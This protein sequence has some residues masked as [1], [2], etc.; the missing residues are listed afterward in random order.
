MARKVKA[1]EKLLLLLIG[2]GIFDTS[3]F[4]FQVTM[5]PNMVIGEAS[6]TKDELEFALKFCQGDVLVI[7]NSCYFGHLESEYW[8]L[9]CSATPERMASALSESYPGYF[10]GSAF[11]AC[12]VAQVAHEHGLRVPLPRDRPSS[13]LLSLPSSPLLHSFSTPVGTQVCILKPLDVSFEE[14]VHRMRNMQQFLIDNSLDLFQVRGSRSLISWTTI[15]PVTFTAEVMGQIGVKPDSTGY[16]TS[17]NKI[18]ATSSNGPQGGTLPTIGSQ[19][20]QFDPLLVKLATEMPEIRQPARTH[21]A[22]YSRICAAFRQH[23]SDPQQHPSPLRVDTIGAESLLLALRS[24]HVQA[25]AIQHIARVLGWCDDAGGVMPFVPQKITNWDFTDMIENGIRIDE[26]PWH[27]KRHHFHE[28][29]QHYAI[30]QFKYGCLF[31]SGCG[32]RW[33]ITVHDG[34]QS[35]GMQLGDL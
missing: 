33:I 31:C 4:Q 12:V 13:Q 8:T 7:C 32:L 25:V 10:R 15:L 22:F 24:M 35:N 9:F 30:I 17:H 29:V 11:T 19:S 16:S 1:G 3:Q 14:F 27:L 28:Y 21:E 26:L 5:Q 20:L 18:F 2:H 23:L 6:I 34:C